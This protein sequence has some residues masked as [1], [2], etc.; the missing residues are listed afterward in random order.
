MRRVKQKKRRGKSKYRRQT[1]SNDRKKRGQGRVDTMYS[2]YRRWKKKNGIAGGLVSLRK[3]G[4]AKF[5]ETW[6]SNEKR[7]IV[8]WRGER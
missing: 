7:N 5:Q 6:K 4:K 8:K 1:I 2:V 3:S